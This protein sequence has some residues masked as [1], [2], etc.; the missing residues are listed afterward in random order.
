[1]IITIF[2]IWHSPSSSV[3][4]FSSVFYYVKS[5]FFSRLC[6]KLSEIFELVF[7]LRRFSPASKV[8]ELACESAL[9]SF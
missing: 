9:R 7:S 6:L 2:F 3:L 5:H 1:M 4:I 8:L